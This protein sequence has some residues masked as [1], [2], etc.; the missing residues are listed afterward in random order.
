M[1]RGLIETLA[2]VRERNGAALNT[3]PLCTSASGPQLNLGPRAW[4]HGSLIELMVPVRERT[5][6]ALNSYSPRV[7]TLGPHSTHGP[8]A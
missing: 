1:H 5:R 2:L 3:S 8:Y 6:A 7:S 4:A